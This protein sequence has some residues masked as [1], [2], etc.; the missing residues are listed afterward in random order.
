MLIFTKLSTMNSNLNLARPR[1]LSPHLGIYRWLIT[2]T[3]SILHRLTGVALS[4]G[5]LYL[6]VWLVSAAY[7]PEIYA[8]F[9]NFAA[10]PLG[11][12][13]LAGWSLAFNYHFCNGIRHMMWDTGRGLEVK[14]VTYSG[15]VMLAATVI[16]TVL[17]WV[18]GLGYIA[19]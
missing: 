2:S 7:Y 8:R 19:I 11:L 6:S 5:L 15:V 18:F 4:I 10:S 14:N 12:L 16:A 13:L 3:L 17:E 9:I 1:P